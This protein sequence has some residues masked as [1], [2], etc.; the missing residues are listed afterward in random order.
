MLIKSI[1][2]LNI[3]IKPFVRFDQ[4]VIYLLLANFIWMLFWFGGVN[5]SQSWIGYAGLSIC[6]MVSLINNWSSRT[7]IIANSKSLAVL[8]LITICVFIL[9]WI[10]PVPYYCQHQWVN[11]M[12]AFLAFIIVK[13]HVNNIMAAT[14]IIATLIVVAACSSCY[15]VWQYISGSNAVLWQERPLNYAN[16]YGSV[17]VNPNHHAGFLNCIMPFAAAFCLLSRGTVVLR[18]AAGLTVCAA[19]FS[20]YLTKSRGGWIAA[21]SAISFLVVCSLRR[22]LT[23]KYLALSATGLTGLGLVAFYFSDGFRERLLGTFSTNTNQSGMFRFWLWNPALQMWFDN[24]IFGVG[25]GQFN[26]RFPAYRTAL[27]QLN[28]IHVHNEY[29]EVLVEFGIIGGLLIAFA[30]HRIY[31]VIKPAVR[32]QVASLKIGGNI[33]CLRGFIIIGGASSIVGSLV[34]CFF[35]FNLRVPAISMLFAMT[36][37]LLLGVIKQSHKEVL[38]ACSRRASM[39][40]SIILFGLVLFFAPIWFKFSREDRL[41]QSAIQS[42]DGS[43]D[44]YH[45]LLAASIVMPENPETHFWIG[46]EIRRSIE[47]NHPRADFSMAQALVWLNRSARLNPFNA[48]TQ[49]TIGRALL[50]QGNI[51]EAH[52]AFEKAYKMSP[53]DILTINPLIGSVIAQGDFSRA[54]LLVNDSLGINDWDNWEAHN[55]KNMIDESEIRRR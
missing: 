7:R 27:T 15:S 28:P 40:Y 18:F 36:V 55:Y 1:S 17:F 8:V 50:Q 20:L 21:L 41:L 10:V 43:P 12:P 5:I 54:R 2:L 9:T 13:N 3:Q 31:I 47:K 23:I 11:L 53:N 49:M 34:H 14:T 22:N 16:R 39:L 45:N 26:I 6:L 51:Q 30:F 25:P 33:D 44:L 32:E 48:R 42:S 52:N 38:P 4:L 29:L 24:L 35:E 19:L 37:S 46:E